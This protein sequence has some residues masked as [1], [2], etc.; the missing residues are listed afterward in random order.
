MCKF[1]DNANDLYDT[2][3]IK[4]MHNGICPMKILENINLDLQGIE[5]SSFLALLIY[6]K[7]IVPMMDEGYF[8]PKMLPK[9]DEIFILNENEYGRP[10]A[11]TS[12]GQRIH[13]EVDPLLIQFN[14]GTIPRGL[15]GFLIVQLLQ[16]NPETYEL[17]GENDPK[18]NIF[19]RC[20]DLIT[21]YIRPWWYVTLIDKISYLELQVRVKG[22]EPSYH[23][24]VQKAVTKALKKVCIA[25]EW[26]Y[27][28]CRYGF[29]CQKDVPQCSATEHLSLLSRS[30]PDCT[31]CKN[32]QSLKLNK[33][34]KI[35]FEVC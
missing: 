33:A 20:A 1:R 7:I 34:Q 19:C 18:N 17:Y 31:E 28:D 21:F 3:D 24:D 4:Q 10:V 6:L 29:L 26:K 35:W 30:K 2:D 14:F 23:Y 9:S 32:K 22:N 11:L 15:F 16:D 5:L 25:F 8:I 12:D 13:Q 27:V